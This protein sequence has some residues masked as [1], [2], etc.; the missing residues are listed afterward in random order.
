MKRILSLFIILNI[1]ICLSGFSVCANEQVTETKATTT[2]K[3]PKLNSEAAIVMDAK[4][5]QVIFQKNAFKRKYP[6]SIT[7]IL[8][9]LVALEKGDLSSTITMSE[10]AVTKIDSDSSRIYLDVGEQINFE[11]A[12]YA[13]M[14]ASA[15][16]AAWG[17]AEHIAG[18]LE[19]FCNMMNEKAASLGCL[20]TH[21]VNANGLSDDNH[22]TTAYDMALITR[23]AINNEKFCQITA[24]TTYEIPPT[25]KLDE[26]R[27][28]YQ[29]NRLIQS[30]SEY[31][32]QYCNGG[33]TGYTNAAGGTLVAW[34]EKDG[35]K[36]ICV[37]MKTAGNAENYTDTKELFEY[38]FNNYEYIEPFTDYAFSSEDI[39]ASEKLLNDFYGGTNLGTMKLTIKDTETLL[40]PISTEGL[41]TSFTPSTD[42]IAKGLIGTITLKDNTQ[43]Y[44]SLPVGF[45]GYINSNDDE[46]IEAAYAAGI[47]TRPKKEKSHAGLRIFIIVVV[48]LGIIALALYLRIM[49]IRKQREEYIRRREAAKK[50]GQTF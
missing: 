42:N 5:G 7:K 35:K 15:N 1:V 27:N 28:I 6:A 40:L 2:H 32:Y 48:V 50:N 34:G 36:L 11:D 14:L 19:E 18:S 10:D 41:T 24:T 16:E 4:T 45:S 38:C 20:D 21:F 22:Y 33:K 31:Y 49:Y 17:V 3:A 8:T 26:P 13:V 29:G 47:L 9:T 30:D 25:N 37:T 44:V 43:E 46:A 12:L 23:E 39:Q